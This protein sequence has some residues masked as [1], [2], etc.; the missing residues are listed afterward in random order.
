MDELMDVIPPVG[1]GDIARRQDLTNLEHGLRAEMAELRGEMRTEI[2]ELRGEMRTE[3]ATV[4]TEMTTALRTHLF[5]M[6]G[7]MFTLAG[8]TWAATSIA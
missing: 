8:L 6:L 4:R 1:W 3:S 2:A 7:A 5:A